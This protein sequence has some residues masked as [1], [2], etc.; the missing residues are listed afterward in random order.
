[1]RRNAYW[2]MFGMDLSHPIAP[3]WT[4]IGN[5]QPWKQDAG[6][7]VNTT[8]R[9]KWAEL[10]R[11]VWLGYENRNN[12]IGPN[13]TDDAFLQL[14]CDSL[15]DM[16]NMRRRGG[17]LA[18]EEFASVA[19]MSWFELTLSA[20]TPIVAALNCNAASPADRLIKIAQ[21]VGMAPAPR[22]RELFDL[23]A[24]M[25]FVLRLIEANAFAGAGTAALFYTPVT[26]CAVRR[27]DEPHRRPVAVGHR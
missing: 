27:R 18:R 15:R 14:I 3:R 8:F 25:S 7:G 23:A 4:A 21:R 26:G 11:Q 24:S 12:G 17:F 16:L 22:A 5:G 2:R 10:L 9:E 6:N 19:V 20:D 1:M 13:A